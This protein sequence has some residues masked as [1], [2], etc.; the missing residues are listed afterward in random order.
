[1]DSARFYAKLR[2]IKPNTRASKI[3]KYIAQALSTGL[4]VYL[5]QTALS[6]SNYTLEEMCLRN[7]WGYVELP[8]KRLRVSDC[9]T[10][11]FCGQ[12]D[13]LHWIQHYKDRI[14]KTTYK[15]SFLK[16][17]VRI[18][19]KTPSTPPKPDGATA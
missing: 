9:L 14:V 2:F 19:Y 8:D 17:Q 15:P 10:I 4:S 12:C 7:G 1:M 16:P 5:G 3:E 11:G 18:E 6:D 13:Y